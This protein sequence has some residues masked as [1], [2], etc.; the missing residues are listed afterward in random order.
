MS[1][2]SAA[3]YDKRILFVVK[4]PLYVFYK[5]FCSFIYT[6]VRTNIFYPENV[7]FQLLFKI[8]HFFL[9]ILLTLVIIIFFIPHF[10]SVCLFFF[11]VVKIFND[12]WSLLKDVVIKFFSTSHSTDLIYETLWR[13]LLAYRPTCIRFKRFVFNK[14]IYYI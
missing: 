8:D 11:T 10:L 6:D 2:I 9:Q 12:I 4:I 5:S 3:N 14:K 1:F 13:A 7:F